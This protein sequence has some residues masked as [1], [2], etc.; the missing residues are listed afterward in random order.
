MLDPRNVWRIGFVVIAL[1]VVVAIGRFVLDGGSG[2]LFTVLMAWFASLAIEPAVSRLSQRMPRGAAT[3]LV[4]LTTV[5]AVSAFL[6]AF[7]QLF[8]TQ[9]ARLVEGLP[10]LLTAGVDQVNATMGTKYE[11]DEI[12]TDLNLTPEAAAGMAAQV[13]GGVLAVLGSVVGAV[14]TVF[15]F[16]LLL[17]Y[18]SADGPRLRRWIASLFPP[19]I[20]EKTIAV[21]DTTAEKTGR[22]VAARVVLAVINATASGIVF[23]IIGLPSWLALAIWTGFIAQFVPV[24]GTYISIVLPVLVGAL[25]PNPWLGLIV[26]GWAV[27]YQQIENLTIEPRISARAVNVHPAVSFASVILGT[28]L[29]GIAGALLAI[30]VVAMLLA[31][32]D[33][34]RTRYEVLPELAEPPA[35]RTADPEDEPREEPV[36]ADTES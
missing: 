6:M 33:L 15:M 34:Y 16:A 9:V 21:W 17:F 4:M 3:G 5:L 28:S 2:L 36:E 35:R 25:S 20:Q 13:A 12:L 14:A 18:L 8:V 29:F 7:G 11:L 24:I 10:E 23:V 31:L 22:Y 19:H 26:A 1:A 32:L 27:L 30:P